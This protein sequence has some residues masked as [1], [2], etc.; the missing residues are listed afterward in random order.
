MGCASFK[1]DCASYDV[2]HVVEEKLKIFG[3]K[4]LYLP[5]IARLIADVPKRHRR[6]VATLISQ[7]HAGNGGTHGS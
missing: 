3:N 6:Q 7:N 2:E 1:M 4:P 5:D